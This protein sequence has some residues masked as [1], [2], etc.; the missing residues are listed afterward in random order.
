MRLWLRETF[1][2]EEGFQLSEHAEVGCCCEAGRNRFWTPWFPEAI[3][4]QGM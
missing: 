4:V 3:G 2:E 1:N